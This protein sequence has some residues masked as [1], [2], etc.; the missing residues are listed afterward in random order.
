MITD[1]KKEKRKADLSPEVENTQPRLRR[2]G[3]L[4]DL[5][6]DAYDPRKSYSLPELMKKGFLGHDVMKDMVP[7]ILKSIKPQIEQTIKVTIENT[8]SQ[9][10]AGA[11]D[12]AINKFKSQVMEPLLNQK[13]EEITL[14]KHE[15]NSKDAKL[16]DLETKIETL[17][18]NNDKLEKGL[19]DLDQYGRRQSI[20]LNNV[21]LPDDS[22]CEEVVLEIINNALLDGEPISH[23]DIERCHPV[24]KP[25]KKKNR[26]IIVKFLSYK[27]KAKVYDA[28]FNLSNIY[29]TEDLT[30]NNQTVATELAKKKKVKKVSKFWSIDGKIF[31]KAHKLQP[32]F[33][34]KTVNDIDTMIADAENKGYSLGGTESES[35]MD[36]S[37]IEQGQQG[38]NP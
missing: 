17:E 38:L 9:T 13:D 8:L 21:S 25:N 24:G 18:I 12:D 16:K 2:R 34:I 27:T 5:Q 20:R 23:N 35:E 15:I 19:N 26:Q 7:S 31:A 14:L 29:M 3:S 6:T 4:P 10:I 22:V 32:K 1:S 33:R 37:R 36:H 11:V 28:R 30:Q